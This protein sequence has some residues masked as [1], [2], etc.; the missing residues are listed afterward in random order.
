MLKLDFFE[1]HN[2]RLKLRNQ[3]EEKSEMETE[4]IR[5]YYINR[6]FTRVNKKNIQDEQ[7]YSVKHEK[8]LRNTQT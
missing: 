3:T 1:S 8:N 7:I 5:I 4:R 2:Y 6:K